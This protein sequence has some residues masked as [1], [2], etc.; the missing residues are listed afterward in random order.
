MGDLASAKGVQG[1][2]LGGKRMA[3]LCGR[4][5]DGGDFVSITGW[6]VMQESW[7]EW[8]R[9]TVVFS[10]LRRGD[11]VR[12]SICKHSGRTPSIIHQKQS[13]VEDDGHLLLPEIFHRSAGTFIVLDNFHHYYD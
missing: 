11:F 8:Q 1:A 4:G 7:V 2:I 9:I 3:E 6:M 13:I 12:V 5:S 10:G